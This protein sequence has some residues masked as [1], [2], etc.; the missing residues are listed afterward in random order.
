[1]KINSVLVVGGG[2]SGW[3][4]AAALCKFFKNTH[5]KISLVESKNIKTIGVGES[6]IASINS[7]LDILELEDEEWMPSCE[8]TYKNSIRF[9]D[10]REKDTVFEYPFGG[11]F[12]NYENGVMT[13]AELAAR[14]DLPPESF[15]EFFNENTFLAMYN[16]CTKNEKRYLDSF[17]F[18]EHT[19]YHFDA[20]L[21]GKFLKEKICIPHGLDYHVD[22]IVSFEKNE[23][24]Y[25][26]SIIGESGQKYSADLFIDCT[27]FKSMIL[28][29]EMGSEFISYKP[30]LLNDKAL[31]TCIP[32]VDKEEEMHNVTNCT[33]IENG[34]V[35]DIPLWHR[36]GTGYVYSSDFVDDETAEKEFR[37]HLARDPRFAERAETA[38]M[39]KINIRHGMRKEAWVK[40]VVG[41]G[42]AYG[43]VE[44]LEST[45]LVSTHS[46]IIR[47]LDV[48]QRRDFKLNKFDIDGYNLSASHELEGFRDF[49]AMHYM[50]S[51]RDDTP[52]WRH[53][54]QEKSFLNL[55]KH[56]QE[57]MTNGMTFTDS[58][59][60]HAH[61]LNIHKVWT[62][63]SSG[64]NYIM[65]G[66]GYKPLGKYFYELVCNAIPGKAEKTDDNLAQWSHHRENLI[67]YI[68]SLPTHYEFLKEN[69]YKDEVH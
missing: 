62:P 64:W 59:R 46:N 13:W 15:S 37:N 36:I 60:A 49:V 40:N 50:C 44:P 28:E 57:R 52:Y 5:L 55:E 25:L 67:E 3:M 32:Y 4:T 53:I 14:H 24:G 66:M 42:L 47:L 18:K 2:S 51:S 38:V 26:T 10:F 19:A 9:T 34:W 69:I 8:A 16:R 11:D 20:E 23:D 39:R 12:T 63:Q 65:G 29:Q 61:F 56:G 54:T 43:F 6:T 33:A 45:G 35:W 41:I 17:N 30:W 1:M 7:Y 68:K 58:F 27:G 48:L 21:F 22:D 31:A